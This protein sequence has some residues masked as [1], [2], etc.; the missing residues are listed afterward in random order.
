MTAIR[1]FTASAVVFDDHDRVL[2]VHHRKVGLWLYPGG[3][4]DENE[5]PAQAARREVLEE[6]G[7]HTEVI[8]ESPFA[9][10]AITSHCPPWAI[11]EMDVEDH[12]TGPHRHIDHLYLLRSVAGELTAQ[13]AEVG[14]ARWVPL[15]GLAELDTPPELPSLVAAAARWRHGPDRWM[16]GS[17]P[18]RPY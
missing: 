2:L 13:L 8:G 3:H 4:I 11:I 16:H 1:H 6:T 18:W 10:P 15:A 9:H 12:R 7:I 5:D 14:A 17:V